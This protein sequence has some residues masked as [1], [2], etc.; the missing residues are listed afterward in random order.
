MRILHWTQAF[1]PVIGGI[2]LFTAELLPELQARGHDCMLITSLIRNDLPRESEFHG[3]PVHRLPFRQALAARNPR[4]TLELRKRV[5][6]L[7]QSFAPE[8]VHITFNDPSVL[9]HL[10]TTSVSPAPTLVTYQ[11]PPPESVREPGSLARRLM[12]HADWVTGVSES[13]RCD[14]VRL[15]PEL[16]D[17][18]SVIYNG[19]DEPDLAPAPLPRDPPRLLCLGRLN[20][21]K[22]IDTALDAFA[23]LAARR[24]RV[25]LLVAG[26]GPARAELEAQAGRLGIADRTDFTGWTEPCDVPALLNTATM[27]L[28]PSRSEGLPFVAVQAAM[29]ARPIVATRVDGLP[30]AVVDGETG[31]LVEPEDAQGLA[32]GIESLL[33]DLPLAERLGRQGREFALDTFGWK[34]CVAGYESVYRRLYNEQRTRK[35]RQ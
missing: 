22:G 9:F 29:M 23:M 15:M 35:G 10:Q 30:E 5:A 17:R 2:E 6:G 26:D 34:R 18:S 28:M 16:A 1:L 13:V 7:K 3:I 33:T 27:I 19:A 14:A 12:E 32:A 24:P 4:Q 25:R 21:I 31:I 11:S 8:L 20:R